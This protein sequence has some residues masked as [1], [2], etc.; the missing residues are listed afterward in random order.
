MTFG[1]S[2]YDFRGFPCRIT[3]FSRFGCVHGSLLPHHLIGRQAPPKK[4]DFVG[5]V[6]RRRKNGTL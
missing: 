4:K 2:P 1:I 6:Q 3:M 5:P